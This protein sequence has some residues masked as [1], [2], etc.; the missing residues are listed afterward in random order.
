[1]E[2]NTKL[3]FE[4]NFTNI[5]PFEQFFYFNF[6]IVNVGTCAGWI[7]WLKKKKKRMLWNIEQK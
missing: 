4:I 5:Q 3:F 7:V 6:M 1:M 2:S